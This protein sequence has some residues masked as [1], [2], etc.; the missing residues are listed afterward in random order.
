EAVGYFREVLLPLKQKVLDE[1]QLQYNAMAAGAFQ[2]LAAKRD[3]V[4]SASAY[5]DQLRE[6]WLARTEAEQLLAGRL[7]ARLAASDVSSAVT[8]PGLGEQAH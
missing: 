8:T 6:Y 2:L 4:E 7:G 1:T 3:Q 5:I